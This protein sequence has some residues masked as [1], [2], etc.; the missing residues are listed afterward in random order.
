MRRRLS[1][2]EDVLIGLGWSVASLR[3]DLLINYCRRKR[4]KT[5]SMVIPQIE[6]EILLS[7]TIDDF[8]DH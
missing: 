6:N 3:P 8:L 1:T 5:S 7:M 4:V 2:P